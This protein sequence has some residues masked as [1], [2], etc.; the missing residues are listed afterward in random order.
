MLEPIMKDLE[1]LVVS[2]L[3]R[4]NQNHPPFHSSH[5]GMAVI[6]EE[7]EEA[8]PAKN[9]KASKKANKKAKKSGKKAKSKKKK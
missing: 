7:V 5:E 1:P 8:K 4:A 9:K 3:Y 6:E 2:E